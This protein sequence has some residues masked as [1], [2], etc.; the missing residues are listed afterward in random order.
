MAN[1][2]ELAS[3]FVPILDD[4]YKAQS[5]TEGLDTGTDQSFTGVNEVKVLKVS[6]TGLGDYSRTDGYPKGDVAASWETITLTEERGKEISIYRMDNE[7]IIDD[8]NTY[9]TTNDALADK[10]NPSTDD[11]V[12]VST[13]ATTQQAANTTT[14][15]VDESMDA[16]NAEMKTKLE[17]FYGSVPE[18]FFN[19]AKDSAGLFKEGLLSGL[20]EAMQEAKALLD[21]YFTDSIV[22]KGTAGISSTSNSYPQKHLTHWKLHQYHEQHN[23]E[24]YETG[25][26]FGCH[27]ENHKCH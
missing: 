12:Q 24:Q 10:I 6:T 14:S 9:I 2:F 1:S 23:Q 27:W 5:V 7:E 21:S 4:I 25:F 22:A 11:I 8:Y 16:G 3:K 13:D 18:G 20:F 26:R 15:I 19:C 17:A